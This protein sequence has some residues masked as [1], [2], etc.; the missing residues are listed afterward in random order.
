MVF[1]ADRDLI[2]PKTVAVAL[3]SSTH[4]VHTT[5]TVFALPDRNTRL[6][7]LDQLAA[8]A[9]R[10]VTMRCARRTDHRDVADHEPADA[11]ERRQRDTRE[12]ALDLVGDR[13]ELLL[14]HRGV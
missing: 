3:T 9:K 1:C 13:G 10:L 2:M 12:L 14:G 6:D 4:P 11:V 8:R 7:A 5:G